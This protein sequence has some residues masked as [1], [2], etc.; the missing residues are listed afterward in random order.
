MFSSS[1]FSPVEP[2][3]VIAGRL[4]LIE[5]AVGIA[6]TFALGQLGLPVEPAFFGMSLLNLYAAWYLAKAA[7]VMGKNT[8][9]Y[10]ALAGLV[11]GVALFGFYRLRQHE[12]LAWLDRN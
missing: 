11:P 3:L 5:F 2:N 8:L 6:L 9:F 4:L 12:L 10:G 7:K 1:L